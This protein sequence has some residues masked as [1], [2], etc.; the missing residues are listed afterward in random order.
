VREFCGTA[1]IL[2]EK[3][4]CLLTGYIAGFIGLGCEMCD[5]F[6]YNPICIGE[7]IRLGNMIKMGN[8]IGD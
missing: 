1:P 7:D 4:C 3:V 8:N 5:D 2:D 6:G